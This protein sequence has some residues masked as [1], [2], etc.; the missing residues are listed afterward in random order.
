MLRA[1]PALS[2]CERVLAETR[3]SWEAP[4]PAPA[5][6]SAA[7]TD[8]G[9]QPAAFVGPPELVVRSVSQA[10]DRLVVLGADHGRDALLVVARDGTL[11]HQIRTGG[12]ITPMDPAP[13]VL[14]PAFPPVLDPDELTLVLQSPLA[15]PV[16]A[17]LDLATGHVRP[18]APPEH[19]VPGA[20]IRRLW[21]DAADGTR[22]CVDLVLPEA[23][24]EAFDNGER[25]CLSTL[26]YGYGHFGTT[27]TLNWIPAVL[28]VLACGGAFAIVHLRGGGEYGAGPAA[29]ERTTTPAATTLDDLFVLTDLLVREGLADADRLVFAGCSAG[30]MLGAAAAVQRPEVFRAVVLAAPAIDTIRHTQLRDRQWKG[31]G[32][33]D[34]AD[35]TRTFVAASP[36]LN[37]V[38]GRRYPHVFVG[39]G[40]GDDICPPWHARKLVAALAHAAVAAEASEEANEAGSGEIAFRVWPGDHTV[41]FCAIGGPPAGHECLAFALH[42]L[43]LTP[44]K[45]QR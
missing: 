45:D 23:A 25:P 35:D 38:A 8:G 36:Y 14:P 1:L 40:D 4:M 32:S 37:I 10:G 22:L 30:G 44:P 12:G 26:V 16:V 7:P 39:C 31:Y 33:L 3:L 41:C 11:L 6:A 2:W 18:H 27:V 19:V 21:A 29:W 24:A 28:P 34:D 13:G 5:P 15:S 9:A 42:H 17:T 43:G 20:A